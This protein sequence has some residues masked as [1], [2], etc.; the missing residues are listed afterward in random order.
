MEEKPRRGFTDRRARLLTGHAVIVG[1]IAALLLLLVASYWA[2]APELGIYGWTVVSIVAGL[3]FI[4]VLCVFGAYRTQ[5]TADRER[6]AADQAAA[7]LA[8][9]PVEP[10]APPAEP[11]RV[12]LWPEPVPP[13][14]A[15]RAA[16]P[17]EPA[18]VPA[19]AE[20]VRGY[21][22]QIEVT[23]PAHH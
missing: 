23:E 6:E 2:T 5:M 9:G 22:G 21:A 15:A 20:V 18:D 4:S 14:P 11:T 12:P 7:A 19:R 17:A 16:R 10:D 3:A 13:A 1:C 8:F